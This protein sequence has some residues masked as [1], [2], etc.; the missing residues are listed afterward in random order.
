MLCVASAQNSYVLHPKTLQTLY[1]TTQAED[2]QQT[3]A[4]FAPGGFVSVRSRPHTVHLYDYAHQTM[5]F[6]QIFPAFDFSAAHVDGRATFLGTRT[7]HVLAFY[8]S[9]L[10][11]V[12]RPHARQVN[13]IRYIAETQTVVTAS[14]DGFVKLTALQSGFAYLQTSVHGLPAVSCAVYHN[15]LVSCGG[16]GNVVFQDVND[17]LRVVMSVYVGDCRRVEA[18]ASGVYVL[19]GK[20]LL[21]LRQISPAQQ[22]QADEAF[23]C[24]YTHMDD[25]TCLCASDVVSDV[26]LA[27]R[28][29]L[30]VLSQGGGVQMQQLPGITDINVFYN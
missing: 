21:R 26:F 7:G 15:L 2:G 24:L 29:R 1:T 12:L 3:C 23:E 19:A 14:D 4:C 28:E 10:L 11:S 13:Q 5:R 18:T 9:Q 16:D 25:L 20:R 6:R 27:D 30:V 17:G 22:I 8:E